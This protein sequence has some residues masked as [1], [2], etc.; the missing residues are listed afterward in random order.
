MVQTTADEIAVVC[1]RRIALTMRSL[2][3]GTDRDLVEMPVPS[4]AAASAARTVPLLRRRG[5]VLGAPDLT[6]SDLHSTP[7]LEYAVDAMGLHLVVVEAGNNGRRKLDC[8]PFSLFS[9]FYL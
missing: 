5:N 7:I 6:N 1:C 3:G 2:T 9:W 8:Q 4:L